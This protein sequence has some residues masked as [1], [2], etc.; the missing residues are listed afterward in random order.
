MIVLQILLL[1]HN[2][3]VLLSEWSTRLNLKPEMN[4]SNVIRICS[5]LVCL[6]VSVSSFAQQ[7][8]ITGSVTNSSGDP[9]LGATIFV[10]EH[11]AV[12]TVTRDKGEF[13]LAVP[14]DAK[15]LVV[16]YTGMKTMDVE[17]TGTTLNIVMDSD[18][19]LLEEVVVIGY[20]TVKRKDLTGSVASVKGEA[21]H[22]APVTNVMEAITG[23][24][25]GVQVTTTEGSPDAEMSIRVRGGGSITQSNEPLY[26]VDGF[27]VSSLSDIPSFDIETIDVLKDASS[28]AIYGSRGANGVILVTTKSGKEGKVRVSYNAS[29]SWKKIAKTLDVLTPEDYANWQYELALLRNGG[30]DDSYTDYFGSYQDMDLYQNV[31]YNDW[32]DLTFGRTGH[33]FNH[34]LSITGGGEKLNYAF[35][36]SNMNDKSIMQGSSF[37]RD[38]LSLKLRSKPVKG[39]TLNFSA[40]YADTD[41]RGGGANDASSSYDTDKR[42]K[43]SV[44]YTPVPIKN[45][46]AESGSG[47][48]DLGNLYHPLTAISDN[49]RRQNRKTLNMVGSAEW[50]V[51]DNLRLKTEIGVDNYRNDDERYW[52]L[53][54][55]YIKNVPSSENQGKPAI[56]IADTDRSTLRNTNTINYDF[57]NVIGGGHSLNLLAGHEYIIR[58]EKVLT[59]IVHGFPETFSAGDAWKY[60][61]EGN[62][63]SVENYFKPDDKLLSFFTRINYDYMSKYLVSFTF[64]ADGSSKFA[65]ENH[66]GY[67]PSAAAAWRVSAEPFMKGSEKWLDDLKL[68]FSVG[69]AGNNNIPSGQLA[70]MY[71]SYTSAYVNGFTNYWGPKRTMPNPDLKWET[72]VTR[73][74]GLD[75]TMF[76]GKLNATIDAYLNTTK[77]L[78]IEASVAGSGYRSQYRNM[79]KTQNKG[80]EFTVNWVAVDKKNFG[81][82][83]SANIGFNKNKVKSLG[84]MNFYSGETQWASSEIGTDYWIVPGG[85]IGQMYGY[86]SDGRYELDD[87]V[88]YD[89]NNWILKDGVADASGV[90]GTIRPGSMKLRKLVDDG[91]NAI[92]VDDRKVIGNANPVHTGGFN[93]AAR[94][95]GFDFSANFN[96]SVGN[97]VYNAN[98]IEF[99]QTGKYQYRNMISAME[100]GKRW[101]N[102][103]PDGTISNDAN[104]LREMNANTTMWSPHT[105]RMVFSDW[106][107]E[108]GSFLRLN[109]LTLGYTLPHHLTKRVG[110]QS[111]RFYVTA[112]NVF[113]ISGYSGYDPE[114]STIRKSNLTPGVDYSAYPKSRQ[115][116]VGLSLNF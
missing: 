60:S 102:L 92:T 43:Y 111:L 98:K 80:I 15:T 108:D 65:K 23:R 93:V 45:L 104:E 87:F 66:W 35:S 51:I 99:T 106:A 89:G 114:V 39:V 4:M 116:M 88:G 107:V 70:T 109:T 55:Y 28:T 73:N 21:L 29:Y 46:T 69:T 91:T 79:G 31:P 72:T 13:T 5:L 41:I 10:K 8:T 50:E 83:F 22:G 7:R 113:C 62:A 32:Q 86:V 78:L 49:D 53:T 96:W 63:H 61:N 17:I 95:Y 42:L 115:F 47:D 3:K 84:N 6:F 33:V 75:F 24:L 112:Y 68:R 85:A 64:R 74:I 48:D 25:A 76:R 26:I 54:T 94:F 40:R 90:V 19:E 1:Y 12:G 82:D 71:E 56:Q 34:N 36:Y 97:D 14:N 100:S 16:S 105:A 52:G 20:G 58:K 27:P 67:F 77:D 110:I 57:K 38:N 11:R 9:L 44:I 37:K 2:A 101:T 30:K 59:S 81:L 103:R 18:Q